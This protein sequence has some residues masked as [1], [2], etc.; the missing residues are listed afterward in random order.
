MNILNE[1]T[2]LA[3]N[4]IANELYSDMVAFAQKLLQKLQIQQKSFGKT[5]R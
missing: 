4:E 5:A 2:T 3:I 1:K